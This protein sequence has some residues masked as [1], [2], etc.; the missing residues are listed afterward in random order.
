MFTQK[1]ISLRKRQSAGFKRGNLAVNCFFAWLITLQAVFSYGQS[2][3]TASGLTYTNVPRGGSIA[4]WIDMSNAFSSDDQFAT[5]SANLATTS[6]YTDYLVIT[7]FNFS[8]PTGSL[9]TGIQ[10]NIER[11][12]DNGKTKDGRLRLV[13]DYVIGTGDR[14]L[15]PAWPTDDAVQSY[16]SSTDLWGD[17]WTEYDVTAE[18][19]GI[20]LTVR[21][22]G[23]GTQP[24]L[25]E[26]DHVFITIHYSAPL[27]V[28]LKYFDAKLNDDVVNVSWTTECEINNDYFSIHKSNDGKIFKEIAKVDGAGNSSQTR[29]Y[30]FIDNTPYRG[31]NFYRLAQT[32]FDG[33]VTYTK[34]AGVDYNPYEPGINV[35]PNPAKDNFTVSIDD[36]ENYSIEIIEASGKLKT[37]KKEISRQAKIDCHDFDNGTFLIKIHS[38]ERTYLRRVTIKK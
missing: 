33:T 23:G 22:S 36:K 38:G 7:N 27:P 37:V 19:F 14:A 29:H 10:V 35:Y 20:A 25:A 21:R 11:S 16:G 30:S 15:T 28:D 34:M 9:I 17:T 1:L 18:G 24:T 6:D 5:I 13:K 3:Q 2:S 32:D 12:D 4:Q 31:K 26:V 8:I